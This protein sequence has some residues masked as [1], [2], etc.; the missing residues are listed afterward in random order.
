V[1]RLGKWGRVR[2]ALALGD[3][4]GLVN[5]G[6]RMVLGGSICSING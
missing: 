6:H 5:P 4:R 2:R 3:T 1:L